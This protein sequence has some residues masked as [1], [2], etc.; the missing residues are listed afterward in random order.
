VEEG[1]TGFFFE[2]GDVGSL[3][4]AIDRMMAASPRHHLMRCAV[5]S[6]FEDVYDVERNYQALIDIYV[7][8]RAQMERRT[9]ASLALAL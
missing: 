7:Q 2:P 9:R 6:R 8:A 3:Q 4:F 1:I 5:R